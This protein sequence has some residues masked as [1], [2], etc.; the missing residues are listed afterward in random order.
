MKTIMVLEN[1]EQQQLT[2]TMGNPVFYQ[3]GKEEIEKIKGRA[4]ALEY[5]LAEAFHRWEALEKLRSEHET[6][7][8]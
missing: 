5:E 4:S 7:S 1:N 3:K 8:S 6:V 2:Q